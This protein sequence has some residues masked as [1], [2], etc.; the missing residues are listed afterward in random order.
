M[1]GIEVLTESSIGI[2]LECVYDSIHPKNMNQFEEVR[3]IYERALK[4]VP[5][6]VMEDNMDYICASEFK[7]LSIQD[8]FE[9]VQFEYLKN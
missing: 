8:L 7:K 4:I 1:K 6:F 3:K 5:E 2:F 9:K